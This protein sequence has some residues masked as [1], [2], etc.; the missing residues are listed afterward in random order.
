MHSSIIDFIQ[1]MGRSGRG[2]DSNPSNVSFRR[3]GHYDIVLSMNSFVYIFERIHEPS[4]NTS[5]E[6]NTNEEFISMRNNIITE[7]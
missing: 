6:T 5:I 2:Y 4:E 7:E 1:E 3:I